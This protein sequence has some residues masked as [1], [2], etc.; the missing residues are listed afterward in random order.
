MAGDGRVVSRIGSY[1]GVVP[2]Q[3]ASGPVNR[4][5][6]I[7]REGPS[8]VRGLLAEAA[9]QAI[10]RSDRV[11]SFYERVRRGDDERRKIALVATVH[12]LLRVMLTMLQSGE[13]WRDESR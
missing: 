6:H 10:R 9:W 4:L 12:Y 5:E 1:F 8:V 3:D 13:V 2:S 11:R 7:T